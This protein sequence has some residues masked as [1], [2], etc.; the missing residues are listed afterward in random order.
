MLDG[1]KASR[2]DGFSLA[3]YKTCWE[4]IKGDLMLV[5]KDF[6]EKYFPDEGSNVTY[7]TLIPKREGMDQISYFKPMNLVGST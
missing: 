1:D 6:Y 7:T 5:I 3:F 2:P 4:V